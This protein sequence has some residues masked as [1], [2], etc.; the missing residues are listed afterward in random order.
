MLL[1]LS[2]DCGC[3]TSGSL[4]TICDE[5]FGN[6]ACRPNYT[7]TQC[8]SCTEGYYGFPN[9]F[10]CD[11]NAEGSLEGRLNSCDSVDGQCF[12]KPT[13]SGQKCDRCLP[14]F[15]GFPNCRQCNC[16][17]AGSKPGPRNCSISNNVSKGWYTYDVHF[18][19]GE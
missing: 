18:E 12:C 5:D 16:N 6:C 11:C 13:Y 9:C 15:Y 1:Y 14:G 4:S 8:D 17:P 2:K 3:S 19:E 7:G 10:L